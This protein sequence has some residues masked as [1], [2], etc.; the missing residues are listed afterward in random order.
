GSSDLPPTWAALTMVKAAHVGGKSEEPLGLGVWESEGKLFI[1]IVN[2][3]APIWLGSRESGGMS[4]ARWEKFH[5]ALRGADR[6][7]LENFGRK[8]QKVVIEIKLGSRAAAKS[9]AASGGLAAAVIPE[10]EKIEIRPLKPGEEGAL[11]RLFYLVYGYDYVNELVYYPEKL[12][13]LAESGDLLSTVAA[14]PNGR[15]VGHVGLVRK[16]RNPPVYE[17]AMGVVDPAAKSRG[18]FS[19][20]FDRIME[21]V[22]A[23]PM[24]YCLFDF[25]TNH[26]YSQRHVAKFQP[27][28]LALFI[29]CQTRKTQAK[30]ERIGLGPDP[31]GMDRY[32]LLVSAIPRVAQPFGP[33]VVLPESIGAAFGFLLKPFNLRWSVSSRFEA[34]PEGGLCRS[35]YQPLQSAVAFDLDRPGRGALDG[36]L[37][38]WRELL[39]KG[40]QY[41][42]VEFPLASPGL[43]MLCDILSS[44]GFFAAGFVPYRC[45]AELGFRFQALGPTRVAFDKIKVASETGRRLLEIV[46]KEYEA[47]AVL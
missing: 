39:R 23:T 12:K 36:L 42:A 24:Q 21:T 40:C 5:Q 47:C 44:N 6:V 22:R 43:G 41:A 16:S 45:G 17:A 37:G 26:E 32:S 4:A 31:E 7:S 18:L 13:A 35:Q 10:G 34:M 2:R 30:L 25:V 27:C 9:L 28:E 19:Q 11:S 29:G 15:L 20:L 1:E 3:G 38:E 14:R 33:E 8:G 46:R